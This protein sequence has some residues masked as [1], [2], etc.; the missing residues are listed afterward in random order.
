MCAFTSSSVTF[1]I[2]TTT[3]P[4]MWENSVHISEDTAIRM[5]MLNKNVGCQICV[6]NTNYNIDEILPIDAFLT[7][8]CMEAMIKKGTAKAFHAEIKEN[9]FVNIDEFKLWIKENTGDN[10]ILSKFIEKYKDMSQIAIPLFMIQKIARPSYSELI[11]AFLED[12]NIIFR[13]SVCYGHPTE[14]GYILTTSAI[15]ALYKIGVDIQLL[16]TNNVYIPESMHKQIQQDIEECIR[17]NKS[18]HNTTMGVMDDQIFVHELSEDEKQKNLLDAV[19]LRKFI[20]GIQKKRNN[21]NVLKEN[22]SEVSYQETLGI[23]DYDS[24]SIALA[25]KH[26]FVSAE[27]SLLGLATYYE[28]NSSCILD[29]LCE[30][31]T[32]L[33]DLIKYMKNMLKF[34]FLVVFSPCSMDYITKN[35]FTLSPEEQ[36]TFLKE[37]D[38]YL[39]SIQAQDEKYKEICISLLNK[40]FGIQYENKEN[41]LNNPVLRITMPHILDLNNLKIELQITE[42]GEI[43]TKIYKVNNP[44]DTIL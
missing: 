27:S 40:V 19:N 2:G 31:N 38:E 43:K 9:T 36:K 4:Y 42:D 41:I 34:K 22:T 12:K 16:N 28:I 11:I 29:F 15:I 30:I 26:K 7:R 35:F 21:A 5:K 6:E 25:E 1:V 18:E 33:L 10:E 32:P 37:W 23:S 8:C 39:K 24:F 14:N 17:Q 3:E 20:E 44:S 13:D